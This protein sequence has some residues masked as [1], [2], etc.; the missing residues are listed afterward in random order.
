[1]N[2]ESLNNYISKPKCIAEISLNKDGS[3]LEQKAANKSYFIDKF[4]NQDTF[5]INLKS[6]LL[7]YEDKTKEMEISS[8]RNILQSIKRSDSTLKDSLYG[9]EIYCSSGILKKFATSHL[10]NGIVD[11]WCVKID[12]VIIMVEDSTSE[13]RQQSTMGNVEHSSTDFKSPREVSHYSHRSYSFERN[14]KFAYSH[15]SYSFERNLKFAAFLKENLVIDK[16]PFVECIRAWKQYRRVYIADLKNPHDPNDKR[17]LRVAYNSII[18]C[19]DKANDKPVVITTRP[20]SYSHRSYSFER[21]LKFA[22]FLKENLV[23]DKA[24]FVECIR[25]WKQYRRVY[26]ADLKNP[27]DPNDKRSLRVA[28]N[29]IIHCVDKANDK[30]VVITT[31]PSSIE[32]INFVWRSDQLLKT[33]MQSIL[34]DSDKV[35]I[36]EC[37][38]N[39]VVRS[40]SLKNTEG[41]FRN[42]DFDEKTPYENLWYVISQI[43]RAF[44]T[45]GEKTIKCLHL[46]KWN[47]DDKFRAKRFYNIPED[48][49]CVGVFEDF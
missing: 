30:P 17:S 48:K 35:V 26:I 44:E 8:R 5:Y 32:G 25:A 15:R 49:A 36:G 7:L 9:A 1:M 27:H 11:V 10:Q 6:P 4:I 22:A 46:I 16:A 19:V 12:G 39:H 23:I 42:S 14:L 24:P 18:H 33:Y 28:Y 20:S 37:D 31:R 47:G 41:L 43:Q 45:D 3:I 13:A 34:L 29:S 40:I 2:L 21:N 38:K